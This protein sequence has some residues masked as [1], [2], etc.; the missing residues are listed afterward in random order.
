M[1]DAERISAL[2]SALQAMTE[3]WLAE[4][5]ETLRLAGILA[6]VLRGDVTNVPE[7]HAG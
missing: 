3:N 4:R 7:S 1:T 6:A 5:E 2:Q